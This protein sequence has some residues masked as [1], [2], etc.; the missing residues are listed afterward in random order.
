VV[1][2][3]SI[4]RSATAQVTSSI[5]S[6]GHNMLTLSPGAER[7][8]GGG[9]S[10]PPFELDDVEALQREVKGLSAVAPTSQGS[11]TLIVGNKNWRT[12]ATGTTNE[13]LRVRNYKV[14]SGREFS[15]NE[16]KGGRPVCLIGSTTRKEL[17]GS[18]DPV[19]E[20][21]RISKVTFEIV[22]VL[23]PKGEGGMGQDQDDLVL[24]PLIAFQR[25]IAGNRDVSTIFLSVEDGK[26]TS[27]VKSQVQMLMRERRKLAA[28]AED[29]FNV[30]DMQEIVTAMQGATTALTA[31]LGAIA[32]VSLLV[33]GIGIMNIML[34]SVTERT[35]EIGTRLAIG[36]TDAEVLWQFLVEA[37]LLST[38]GG[39]IGVVLGIGGS[40]IASKVLDMPFVIAPEI[41]AI[42]FLFSAAVGVVF[43]YLPAR[44]AARLQPI[45]ALRHE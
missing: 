37:I 28:D 18:L 23:A 31:L 14:A 15:D 2:L 42:A 39:S 3:V 45:E 44:T 4:G 34:V 25:K 17:F 30:R 11:A 9:S 8:T 22:G 21:V 35:R 41:V 24:M 1:A 36:A 10:A 32:A 12:S 33:G 5:S 27:T 38:L 7:R 26:S 29:D 19:G 43:G 6:L 20:T 40:L 16:V 13:F